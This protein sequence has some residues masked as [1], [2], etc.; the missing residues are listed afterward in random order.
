MDLSVGWSHAY[1]HELGSVVQ[2]NLR[3]RERDAGWEAEP[4][5]SG[6]ITLNLSPGLTLGL[7]H[8]STLYAYV[9]VPLYQRVNGIQLV[10]QHA[11]AIGWTHEF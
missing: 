3:R 10:P 2:L 1:S 11:L 6:S 8:T 7:G 5:N 4:A 9:Q